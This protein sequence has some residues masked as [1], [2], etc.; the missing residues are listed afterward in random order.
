MIDPKLLEGRRRVL[1]ILDEL[2]AANLISYSLTPPDIETEKEPHLE[3]FAR[4]MLGEPAPP[5]VSLRAATIWD[6][7][8][9]GKMHAAMVLFNAMKIG[10][11]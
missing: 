9:R 1:A 2:R 8:R 6:L 7:L 10:A 3:V 4:A 11:Q 5:T